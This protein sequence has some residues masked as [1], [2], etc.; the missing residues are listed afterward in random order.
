[1][2]KIK[3]NAVSLMIRIDYISMSPVSFLKHFWLIFWCQAKFSKIILDQI[4]FISFISSNLKNC[5]N[6]LFLFH[7]F[8]SLY[9]RVNFLIFLFEK[10]FCLQRQNQYYFLNFNSFTFLPY[11]H[12]QFPSKYV[13]GKN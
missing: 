1:M 7:S 5:L 3:N 10:G 12:Y 6:F 4:A 2:V 9:L 11:V 13:Y 8:L